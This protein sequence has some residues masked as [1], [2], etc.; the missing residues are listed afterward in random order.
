MCM[1]NSVQELRLPATVGLYRPTTKA[2]QTAFS[3]EQKLKAS[4]E[5][6]NLLKIHFSFEGSLGIVNHTWKSKAIHR[7]VQRL[8]VSRAKQPQKAT[9]A[10][11]S[12]HGTHGMIN[13]GEITNYINFVFMFCAICCGIGASRSELGLLISINR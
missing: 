5:R 3:S 2:G 9:W 4:A 8:H 10:K 6:K 12:K 1:V 7:V 13:S 11:Q